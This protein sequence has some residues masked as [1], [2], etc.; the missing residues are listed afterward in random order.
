[1]ETAKEPSTHLYVR[2]IPPGAKIILDE[3]PGTTDGLLSVTPG[4]H[5]IAVELDGYAPDRR[6]V[7]VPQGRITRVEVTLK[8]VGAA[9]PAPGTAVAADD[10]PFAPELGA[11]AKQPGAKGPTGGVTGPKTQASTPP[12]AKADG[13]SAALLA[14]H[15]QNDKV[16]DL[17]EKALLEK[18]D[19]FAFD[20]VPLSDVVEHLR[21]TIGKFNILL[22]QTALEDSGID[23]STM[24]VTIAMHRVSRGSAIDFMLS[25]LGLTWTVR[26]G[27]MVI[28][29]AQRAQE[30]LATK[31]Y[32]IADL[33][34]RGS[35]SLI[36][37]ITSTIAPQTWDEAGGSGSITLGPRSDRLVIRQTYRVHRQ[38]RRLLTTLRTMDAD[39]AAAK[40]LEPVVLYTALTAS[41][42][43]VQSLRKT[44]AQPVSEFEF[45]QTPLTDVVDFIARVHQIDAVLDKNALESQSI[46]PSATQVTILVRKI[47]LGQAIS[48]V[49]ERVG[50]T[51]VFEG[52]YVRITTKDA[53]EQRLVV[54]VY[55][56][57]DLAPIASRTS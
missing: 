50:L 23:P 22:D 48:L 21:R 43:D 11:A 57:G 8:K 20:Q 32:P 7:E 52:D 10:N 51:W 55:P 37:I 2:T 19:E 30:E 29:T 36:Q 33:S 56:L 42:A 15:D 27:A 1:M 18:V 26:D 9:S 47:P 45:D 25:Q 3:Q 54:G 38:V 16:E 12:A 53:A 35:D 34:L 13:M 44:L 39:A 40:A 4:K 6:E 31:V 28:T 24:Q 17:V 14:G 49:L 41:P 46:D 5:R